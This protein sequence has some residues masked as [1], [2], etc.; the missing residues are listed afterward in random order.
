MHTTA[1][2]QQRMAPDYGYRPTEDAHPWLT[3]P[4]GSKTLRVGLCVLAAWSIAFAFNTLLVGAGRGEYFLPSIGWVI[5]VLL[6]PA[7]LC[8]ALAA[9]SQRWL[10]RFVPFTQSLLFGLLSYLAANVIA[11]AF[12]IVSA[13]STNSTTINSNCGSETSC[14]EAIANDIMFFGF[15]FLPL[16]LVAAIGYGLALATVTPQGRRVRAWTI[17]ATAFTAL[18]FA[19][20][21]L[22]QRFGVG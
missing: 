17:G 1:D 3:T 16:I 12:A 4:L 19:A 9:V 6:V 2:K 22:A 10:T 5:S 14:T 11:A 13:F 18:V 21:L 20:A 8:A 15:V 7:L